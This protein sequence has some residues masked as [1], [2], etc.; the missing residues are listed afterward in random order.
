MIIH[1]AAFRG[2]GS[3]ALRTHPEKRRCEKKST[4]SGVDLS[5]IY[6]K[7]LFAIYLIQ[8]NS[9]TYNF[10]FFSIYI[11]NLW[12]PPWINKKPDHIEYDRVSFIFDARLLIAETVNN[13][14]YVV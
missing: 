9:I 14:S 11:R 10:I 12:S 2:G 8:I 4:F 1:Y 13:E 3:R 5:P 6:R 7:L